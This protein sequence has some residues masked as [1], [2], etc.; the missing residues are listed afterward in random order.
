MIRMYVLILFF[1]LLIGGCSKE[2][3]G[4]KI[5][6]GSGNDSKQLVSNNIPSVTSYGPYSTTAG[7]DFN[8]Q[9]NGKSSIWLKT[10]NTPSTVLVRWDDYNLP[11]TYSEK[12][13]SCEV[14]KDLYSK[15]GEHKILIVDTASG[16]TSN[17]VIFFVK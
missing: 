4:R 13:I 2:T 8:V 16:M 12:L 7:T 10:E 11:V 14:P 1:A 5:Q 6:S 9:S 3:G 17:T 15:S